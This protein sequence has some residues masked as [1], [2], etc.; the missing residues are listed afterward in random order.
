[1][2]RLLEKR[3]REMFFGLETKFALAIFFKD[4]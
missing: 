3:R 2:K 4:Y 1:M